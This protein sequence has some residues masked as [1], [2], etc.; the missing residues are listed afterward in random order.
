[1]VAVEI[2][3]EFIFSGWGFLNTSV[4]KY[5]LWKYLSNENSALVN[6]DHYVGAF[7]IGKAGMQVNMNLEWNV[8]K[9]KVQVKG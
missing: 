8:E 3:T 7:D 9:V 4:Q 1:M 5:C 6:T 2:L